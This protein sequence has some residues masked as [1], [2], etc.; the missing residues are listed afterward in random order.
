VTLNNGLCNSCFQR[1]VLTVRPQERGLLAG[2]EDKGLL[3]CARGCGG[4]VIFGQDAA[5]MAEGAQLAPPLHVTATEYYKALGGMG[6]P[7]EVTDDPDLIE[8]LFKAHRVD[9]V[10]LELAMGR[11]FIHEIRLENGMTVHLS[12]GAKGAQVLKV[13]RKTA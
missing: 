5:A 3:D 12:A 10:M 8:A 13:T 1:Y 2:Y 11:I 4:K 6:L 7:D 9:S